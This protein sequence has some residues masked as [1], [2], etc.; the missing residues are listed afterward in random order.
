MPP[1]LYELPKD[2]TSNLNPPKRPLRPTIWRAKRAFKAP[3]PTYSLFV[4]LNV[5]DV[6]HCKYKAHSSQ[7]FLVLSHFSGQNEVPTS[8]YL[9]RLVFNFGG[10]CSLPE[11]TS[12]PQNDYPRRHGFDSKNPNRF[13]NGST[14]PTETELLS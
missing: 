7:A 14:Q 2:V 3:L 13:R 12:D 1:S 6:N 4:L 11:L 8:R 5:L 10:L 9:L